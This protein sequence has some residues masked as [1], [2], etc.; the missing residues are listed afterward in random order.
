MILGDENMSEI[1]NELVCPVCKNGDCLEDIDQLDYNVW[2]I[3]CNNCGWDG[4][5]DD[6][7]VKEEF[8]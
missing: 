4:T 6:L 8:Q 2:A 7:S 1:E 3:K 5:S